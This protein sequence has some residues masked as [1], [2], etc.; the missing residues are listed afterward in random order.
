MD[1]LPIDEIITR[2]ESSDPHKRTEALRLVNCALTDNEQVL[3][4]LV[5]QYYV[6]F[7]EHLMQTVIAVVSEARARHLYDA[8]HSEFR[9]LP[10]DNLKATLVL[11]T[12]LVSRH[13]PEPTWMYLIANHKLLTALLDQLKLPDS[14]DSMPFGLVF[15]SML[16]PLA[17][18]NL[19]SKL[20]SLFELL[21]YVVEV[22]SVRGGKSWD[23]MRRICFHALVTLYTMYPVALLAWARTLDK[24]KPAGYFVHKYGKTL[25]LHAAFLEVEAAGTA[26]RDGGEHGG[27]HPMAKFESHDIIWEISCYTETLDILQE[28]QMIADAKQGE[29]TYIHD[30][31]WESTETEQ[32]SIACQ[33]TEPVVRCTVDHTSTVVYDGLINTYLEKAQSGPAVATH[34]RKHSHRFDAEHSEGVAVDTLAGELMLEK[35]LR[36]QHQRRNRRYLC[37]VRQSFEERYTAQVRRDDWERVSA[38]LECAETRISE[39]TRQCE[40]ERRSAHVQLLAITERLNGELGDLRRRNLELERDEKQN[41]VTV[42]GLEERVTQAG[43]QLADLRGV[44]GTLSEKQKQLDVV[45]IHNEAIIGK[46]K[47]LQNQLFV[48]NEIRSYQCDALNALK[49]FCFKTKYNNSNCV[50]SR[51][52]PDII[53]LQTLATETQRKLE[54]AE[55]EMKR[56]KNISTQMETKITALK[57]KLGK[58]KNVTEKTTN[59]WEQKYSGLEKTCNTYKNSYNEMCQQ[60]LKLKRDLELRGSGYY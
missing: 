43:L 38:E 13:A 21:E 33:T 15:V 5:E 42:E 47:E 14:Y 31:S 20:S 28:A 39:L 3:S 52:T 34:R 24:T 60:V 1:K 35:Y 32:R 51:D 54:H 8:L 40:E 45:T 4:L 6:S 49:P 57:E 55:N 56:Y 26:S 50:P 37:E 19:E 25:R 53:N 23:I 27:E 30:I 59:F 22:F 41:A 18:T 7:S 46:M 29:V 12:N 48:V 10:A 11:L 58:Q 36:Y 44:K 16:L 2:L 17:P 9:R